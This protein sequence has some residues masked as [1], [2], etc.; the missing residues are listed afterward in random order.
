MTLTTICRPADCSGRDLAGFYKND[1]DEV[2]D[3]PSRRQEINLYIQC[4]SI[5]GYC[6]TKP[7]LLYP[8]L[9]LSN[10]AVL[11]IFHSRIRII[12]YCV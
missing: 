4:S 2:I 11:G 3:V 5:G 9:R 7:L 8:S 6:F 12:K 1:D 10:L